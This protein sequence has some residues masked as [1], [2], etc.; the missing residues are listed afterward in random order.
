MT[1]IH[2]LLELREKIKERKPD[3]IRQQGRYL[4]S[5]SKNW[6]APKGMHSKLRK[7]LRGKIKQPSIGYSSPKEA[8]YLHPSGLMPQLISN[9]NQLSGLT[10]KDGIIIS[11]KLGKRKKIELLKKIKE[12]KYKV[13][14]IKDIDSY[15][16]ESEEEKK[17]QKEI[18]A[19]RKQEKEKSKKKALEKAK[20][21][22]RKEETPEE[23]E[24]REKEEKR[25]VLETKA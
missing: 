17:K 4:K 5:L 22:K 13:L 1:Q 23:K 19:G 15:I 7:K 20:K 16:K 10:E 25:K 2:T 6:R 8:R 21:E 3:F 14:N 9:L 18:A 24:K 11:G 12:T